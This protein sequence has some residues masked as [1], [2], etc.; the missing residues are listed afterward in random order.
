MNLSNLGLI[1]CHKLDRTDDLDPDHNHSNENYNGL[2]SFSQDAG[3]GGE[4]GR[5]SVFK[6]EG[7]Y[8]L[9][10]S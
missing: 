2:V 1:L 3:E 5:W 7:G 4:K 10:P 6:M 9:L 8:D